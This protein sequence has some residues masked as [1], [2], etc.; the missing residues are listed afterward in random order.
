MISFLGDF[1]QQYFGIELMI[2]VTNK[3]KV[4][5]SLE[6]NEV[7]FALVSI[8]QHILC[9]WHIVSKGFSKHASC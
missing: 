1:L 7:D 4:V 5:E 8:L 3:N 9:Y 6:N 2:D